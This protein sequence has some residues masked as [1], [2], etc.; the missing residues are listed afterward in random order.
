MN[1]S[2]VTS[3]CKR[4][5]K[6]P[7]SHEQV[8]KGGVQANPRL[9]SSPAA[10]AAA[11]SARAPNEAQWNESGWWRAKAEAL[12]HTPSPSSSHRHHPATSP[13]DQAL[14]PAPRAEPGAEKTPALGKNP[15]PPPS[16][17]L[18]SCLSFLG[19]LSVSGLSDR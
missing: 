6:H 18:T 4:N 12:P 10:H 1:D 2:P 11:S 5:T 16:Q 15:K 9:A 14:L 13:R 8:P 17:R 19:K 7:V 3:F